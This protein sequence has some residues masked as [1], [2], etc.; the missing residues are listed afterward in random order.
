MAAIQFHLD[1]HIAAAI[2]V[3]LRARNIDVTTS[4][5]VGESPRNRR[6]RPAGLRS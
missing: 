5:E 3:G 2:A 1:E 4:A 6:P